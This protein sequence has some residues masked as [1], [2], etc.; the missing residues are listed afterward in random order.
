MREDELIR[1][2]QERDESAMAELLRRRGP[3]MRYIIA[4]ILADER[5]REECISDAALR[6]WDSIGSFDASRGGFTAW[7]SALTR[8]AALN[9]ARAALAPERELTEDYADPDAGPE[10]EILRRERAEA[11]RLAIINLPPTDRSIV[12]RKYYYMQPMAQIAAELGMTEREVEG[13]LYRLKRKL[14]GALGGE[15]RD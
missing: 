7:L 8:N 6:V 3:L 12:Y 14:R 2:L 13:R 9:R 11:L 1:L 5:E 4:P 15:W 10:R